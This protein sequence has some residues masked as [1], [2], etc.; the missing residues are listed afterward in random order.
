MDNWSSEVSIYDSETYNNID[1]NYIDKLVVYIWENIDKF[2]TEKLKLFIKNLSF[3]LFFNLKI[4]LVK[5][6]NN[7][8]YLYSRSSKCLNYQTLR[9]I[10][11]IILEY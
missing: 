2:S 3:N 10:N 8:Y 4:Y 11:S 1:N 9:N 5:K 7:F 6:E